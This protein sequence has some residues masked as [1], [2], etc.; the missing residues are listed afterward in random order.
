MEDLNK[1]FN[2][3]GIKKAETQDTTLGVNTDELTST[4][5]KS[6]Q[7]DG[8]R[9]ITIMDKLEKG[10]LLSGLPSKPDGEGF[11]IE[12]TGEEIKTRLGS[13]KGT[14]QSIVDKCKTEMTSEK[15][16]AGVEP[17]AD[18]YEDDY[19]FDGM[20]HRLTDVPKKYS[21]EQMYEN[22]SNY[23]KRGDYTEAITFDN[24]NS[25]KEQKATAE[26][27]Q[28]CMREYNTYARKWVNHSVELVRL[29][30]IY[31]NIKEKDKYK[32]SIKQASVLGF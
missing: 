31:D 11:I 5:K 18:Y 6:I 21:Y 12:K 7:F 16:K 13:L 25:S 15:G 23:P 1:A 17:D 8:E 4:I 9:N 2:D 24:L 19:M 32:M 20:Y 29:D 27:R 3:L 26:E 28:K 10:S 22:T 14:V 30:T